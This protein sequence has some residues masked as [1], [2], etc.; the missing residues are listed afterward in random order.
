[1]SRARR[2]SGVFLGVGVLS[3][4]RHAADGVVA[5]NG[6]ANEEEDKARYEEF[7]VLVAVV[8]EHDEPCEG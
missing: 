7:I 4:H 5:V 8:A 2:K 6:K 1:M 3:H